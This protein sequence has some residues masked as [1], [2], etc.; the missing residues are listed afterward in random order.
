MRKLALVLV[1]FAVLASAAT[2]APRIPGRVLSTTA[3]GGPAQA[4]NRIAWFEPAGRGC[5][6][7]A[8]RDTSTL[9]K[10]D[11][12]TRVCPDDGVPG[13]F[14]Y[15]GGTAFWTDDFCGNECYQDI[16]ILSPGGRFLNGED[17]DVAY[18]DYSGVGTR[19]EAAAG[20]ARHLVYLENT[21][22]VDPAFADACDNGGDCRTVITRSVVRALAGGPDA[23][24]LDLRFGV[25]ALALQGDTIALERD[26]ATVELRS[27]RTGRVQ[28]TL[29]IPEQGYIDLT[30]SY[31]ALRTSDT[32]TAYRR[33]DGTPA[34]VVDAVRDLASAVSD[35]GVVTAT[36]TSLVV[37]RFDGRRMRIPLRTRGWP[38]V[39]LEGRRLAW[40]DGRTIRMLLLPR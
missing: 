30:R 6:H 13:A 9:R 21:R 7:L 29:G 3:L 11:F 18:D 38:V 15:G 2:A 12:G 5:G 40:S 36:E 8:V 39:S 31:L 26:D 34:L 28:R 10:H 23:L 22:E 1:V 35:A 17:D 24:P 16:S 19:I 37:D 14:A 4:G 20:D 33:S 32:L 25:V 27:I